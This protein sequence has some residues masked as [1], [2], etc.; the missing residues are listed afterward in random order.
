[1]VILFLCV[2]CVLCLAAGIGE[3]NFLIYDAGIEALACARKSSTSTLW[4]NL[5]MNVTQWQCCGVLRFS[6]G[7]GTCDFSRHVSANF[8]KSRCYR[9]YISLKTIACFS[10]MLHL[11]FPFSFQIRITSYKAHLTDVSNSNFKRHKARRSRNSDKGW[12]LLQLLFL[13]S[14]T[15]L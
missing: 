2:L 9:Y 3:I 10:Y 6:G 14:S 5:Q 1:M 12:Q 4:H 7:Q 11:S 13:E 8:D 15:W